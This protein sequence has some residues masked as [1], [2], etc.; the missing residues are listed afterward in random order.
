VRRAGLLDHDVAVALED[1]RRNLA[2]VV[3][4]QGVDGLIAGE[5]ARARFAD[6]RRAQRIRTARPSK[7]WSRSVFTFEEGLRCP[8]G[9]EGSIGQRSVDFLNYWP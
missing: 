3:V 9:L 4:N 6:A 2:D 1:R 8:V 5:N 7:R